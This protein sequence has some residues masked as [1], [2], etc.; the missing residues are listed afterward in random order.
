MDAAAGHRAGIT[1]DGAAWHKAGGTHERWFARLY[2]LLPLAIAVLAAFWFASGAIDLWQ[3][4]AA[5]AVLSKHGFSQSTA[6]LAV[7]AGSL[8]DMGLGVFI[9][10][11][12]WTRH[13]ALDMVAVS[14]GYLAAAAVWTPD[15][16]ADPL[17]PML[18]VLPGMM[19]AVLVA[20]LMEER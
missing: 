20:A 13:A 2:L 6:A 19:L 9:L 14:A 15:F 10:L 7:Y 18:K 1:G 16:Y 8:I 12:R 17:G 11:R 3:G 5:I 4:E